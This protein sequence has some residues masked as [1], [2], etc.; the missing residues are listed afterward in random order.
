M[1]AALLDS[2]SSVSMTLAQVSTI[3]SRGLQ[4]SFA[5]VA[6]EDRRGSGRE[7]RSLPVAGNHNDVTATNS[8][9]NGVTFDWN[10][11]DRRSQ[12][13]PIVTGD[14]RGTGCETY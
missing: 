13:R 14:K 4:S 2:S 11:V 10:V 12:S 1:S 9:A 5:S 8:A 6:A 3:S 7:R